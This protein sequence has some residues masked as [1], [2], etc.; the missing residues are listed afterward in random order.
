VE[1]TNPAL[2]AA[3]HPGAPFGTRQTI[4]HDLRDL[5]YE[6]GSGVMVGIP[7]QT[8][9]DLA[10]DLLWFQSMDLDMIG[11]GPYI[12]HPDT[13]LGAGGQAAPTDQVPATV[14]M[15]GRVVALARV[16]CPQANIPAT[17]AVA[18]LDKAQGREAMLACGANVIMP[19]L[20]PLAYRAAYEIYPAKACIDET[21]R[22]CRSCLASRLAAIG[23]V[24]GKGKGGR[25]RERDAL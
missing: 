24:P 15:T 5:G 12:A 9:R 8:F 6:I 23:R 13:P 3:I 7:G 4:L 21:A 11:V 18:T 17:T 14:E 10:A 2:Y 16:L 1:T 25:K 22:Q 19:N 20:T